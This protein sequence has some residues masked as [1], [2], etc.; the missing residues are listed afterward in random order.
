MRDPHNMDYSPDTMALT[1][2]DCDAM[3]STSIK[4]P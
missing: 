4:W 2:S 3:R 1:T